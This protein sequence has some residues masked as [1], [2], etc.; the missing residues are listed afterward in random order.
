MLVN[1]DEF[2][3]RSPASRQDSPGVTRLRSP[4]LTLHRQG[5]NSLA[6]TSVYGLRAT[7]GDHDLTQ[8]G[9]VPCSVQVPIQ[10]QPT[11]GTDVRAHGQV[12]FGF[13]CTTPRAGLTR[14]E[15]PI[16]HDRPTTTPNRLVLQLPAEFPKRDVRDV[17]GQTVVLDHPIDVQVLNDDG[18]EL[19]GQTGSQLVE[20][21]PAL[22]GDPALRLRQGR[23]RPTPTIR[24]VPALLSRVVVRADPARHGAV[25]TPDLP[26]RP[27]GMSGVG[28]LLTGRQDR[29]GLDPEVDTNHDIR[30]GGSQRG[31]LRVYGKRHEPAA[32]LKPDRRRQHPRSAHVDFADQPA[33]VLMQFDPAQPGQDS[34]LGLAPDRTRGEPDRAPAAVFGLEPGEPDRCAL[35]FPAAGVAPVLQ[36]PRQPVKAGVESLLRALTPPRRNLTLGRVP[37]LTQ[38]VQR[39][40]HSRR[41][42]LPADAVGG[43]GFPLT[44]D[45]LDVGQPPVVGDSGRT[46]VGRHVAFLR[47]GRVEREPVRQQGHGTSC[48]IAAAARAARFAPSRRPYRRAHSDVRISAWS[49]TKSSSTSAGSTT[50]NLRPDADSTASTYSAPNLAKRPGC[51]TTTVVTS[52]SP[53]NVNS[54]LWCPFSADPTSVTTR[55]TARA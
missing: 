18:P 13:H 44:H 7:P 14:R 35:T 43:F 37:L 31:T 4:G 40:R 8:R 54:F 1:S 30:P 24:R 28:K 55:S 38:R 12:Q 39:P 26:R 6:S 20:S 49:R 22:V 47:R 23:R 48:S 52:R 29:K 16:N 17:P 45:R 36:C 9:E 34:V 53:S 41:Q 27:V 32:P 50:S 42:V 21:V 51:S 15:P 11:F 33:G 19:P 25:Q 3:D 2:P 10:D 5:Q 46:T